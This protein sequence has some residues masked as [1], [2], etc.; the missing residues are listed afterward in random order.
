MKMLFVSSRDVTKKSHG[1]FQGTNKNYESCCALLG[2]ENV[3]VLDLSSRL[4][5]KLTERMKKWVNYLRGYSA[6]MSNQIRDEV[7]ELAKRTDFVFLDYI[8][9]GVLARDLKKAGYKG[10]IICYFHNVEIKIRKE[11]AKLRKMDSWRV[12]LMNRNEKLAMQYAD[13]AVALHAR[14]SRDLQ[15]IYGPRKMELLPV[16]FV[17]YVTPPTVEQLEEFTCTQ[18]VCLFL[19][20]NWY[21]NIQG[22]RWFV[23]NVLD[24]VDIKLQIVGTGMDPLRSQY[25]HPKIEFLG[26]VKSL[27]DV[28]RKA[29]FMLSPIFLGSGMKVKTC[30]ALMFGKNIIGTSELFVGYDLDF[31]K[32]GALCNTPE[33]F[34]VAFD[35]FSKH[36][37]KRYNQYSR[38]VYEQKYSFDATLKIFRSILSIPE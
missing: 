16:S 32:V 15:E 2:R 37:R 35:N 19:G 17:D 28:M 25:I 38:A 23:D 30:E 3:Q 5:E 27:N 20:N 1:G 8:G 10:K 24:H 4:S 6:G 7:L 18:P 13:I 34:V 21:P 14:D 33:E 29:D 9:Y 31:D 22:L 11:Q 26:Y 36:P 12:P